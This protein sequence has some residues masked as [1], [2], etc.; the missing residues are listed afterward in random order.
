MSARIRP[1]P[2]EVLEAEVLAIYGPPLSAVA[3]RRM[4]VQT[5][6]ELKVL[7]GL[8]RSSNLDTTLLAA[9]IRAHPGRSSA[10]AGALLRCIRVIVN[11]AVK[12]RWLDISPFEIRPLRFWLRPDA[13]P[14]RNAG[15]VYH[16]SQSEVSRLLALLN[17][18]AGAN[19]QSRR[20]QSLVYVYVYTAFRKNEAIHVLARNVDFGRGVIV[21]EPIPGIWIPKTVKSARTLPMADPLVDVLRL[22]VPM[23]GSEWLFP[24]TRLKGPWTGGSPGYK[25]VDQIAAAAKRAGIGHTTPIYFR[26]W[27]GTNA[28]AMGLG[29]LEVQSFLGHSNPDTQASYDEEAIETMR[30]AVKKLQLFYATTGT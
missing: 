26:K 5:F 17:G 6:E 22:W 14:S 8:K 3:T 10:R 12:R 24:G 11:H 13:C 20:L 28:K 30:P 2:F 29:P 27:F 9:W 23:C 21:I 4:M 7:P 18:E 16:R 19:W 25:A 1:V 15:R